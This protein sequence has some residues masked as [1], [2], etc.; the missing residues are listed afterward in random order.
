MS[1]VEILKIVD[2]AIVTPVL[3]ATIINTLIEEMFAYRPA[4]APKKRDYKVLY[5]FT[6]LYIGIIVITLLL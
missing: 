4:L 6:L 3:F 1:I 2:L 5:I